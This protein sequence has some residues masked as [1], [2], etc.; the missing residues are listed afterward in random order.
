MLHSIIACR[1]CK[2]RALFSIHL[3]HSDNAALLLL[4]M[5][6]ESGLFFSSRL[7]IRHVRGIS[8]NLIKAVATEKATFGQSRGKL[9]FADQEWDHVL[10]LSL[11]HTHILKYFL[12]GALLAPEHALTH[13]RS[14]TS[15]LPSYLQVVHLLILKQR[16]F[17]CDGSD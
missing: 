1:G 17:F 16:V 7:L 14:H 4:T 13:T 5:S 11:R 9:V 8:W 2:R 12:S 15:A 10:S 6:L 3:K